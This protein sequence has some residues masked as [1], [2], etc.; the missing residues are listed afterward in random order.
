MGSTFAPSGRTARIAQI[1]EAT[2]QQRLQK[3]AEANETASLQ[4]LLGYQT[5]RFGRIYGTAQSQSG[6]RPPAVQGLT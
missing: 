2:E 3:V 4:D 1:Q 6:V 5:R